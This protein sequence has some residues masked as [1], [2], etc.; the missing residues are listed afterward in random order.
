MKELSG[1]LTCTGYF[2][3]DWTKKHCL[4]TVYPRREDKG[5]NLLAILFFVSHYESS[6]EFDT[7]ALWVCRLGEAELISGGGTG[8]SER[9]SGHVKPGHWGCP[10]SHQDITGEPRGEAKAA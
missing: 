7:F 4:R 2:Q 5:V 8:A 1:M 3:A 10:G 9:E 6:H